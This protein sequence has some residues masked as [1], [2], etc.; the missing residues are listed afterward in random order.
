MGKLTVPRGGTSKNRKYV[1]VH[2]LL[3]VKRDRHQIGFLREYWKVSIRPQVICCYSKDKGSLNPVRILCLLLVLLRVIFVIYCLISSIK[4][5]CSQVF[6]T[7]LIDQSYCSTCETEN[8]T[9]DT[10]R[11]KRELLWISIAG[12]ESSPYGHSV[13]KNANNQFLSVYNT[14]HG[15]G[16]V[17][18]N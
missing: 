7:S 18:I 12:P 1:H 4:L 9:I 6:L 5:V 14:R 16:F 3:C 8:V 10:F 11:L 17:W 13:R 15:Q 2:G